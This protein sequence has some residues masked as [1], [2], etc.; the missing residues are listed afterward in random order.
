MQWRHRGKQSIKE[1][2]LTLLAV[3]LPLLR[4]GTCSACAWTTGES[5]GWVQRSMLAA[6]AGADSQQA[7]AHRTGQALRFRVLTVPCAPLGVLLLLL[8]SSSVAPA[9]ML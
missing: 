5:K 2:H 9:A 1:Y 6:G 8:L 3:V 7:V 4:A